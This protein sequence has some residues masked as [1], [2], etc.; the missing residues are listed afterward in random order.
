MFAPRPAASAMRAS[1][2]ST[3]GCLA[4]VQDICTRASVVGLFIDQ[5]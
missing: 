3:F 5:R 2:F 4:S 1:A